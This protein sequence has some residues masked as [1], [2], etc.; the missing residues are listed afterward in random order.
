MSSD[1][2]LLKRLKGQ[3]IKGK[4]N[5]A[6][7]VPC[8]LHQEGEEWAVTGCA[9]TEAIEAAERP[10]MSDTRG[11][12]CHRFWKA[13]SSTDSTSFQDMC[14]L[15]SVRLFATPWTAAHQAPL[16]MGFPKQEY[17]SGLPF[18]TSGDLSNQGMEL[19]SPVLQADSLLLTHQGSP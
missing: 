5:R 11:D 18:P 4:S 7:F 19:S 15:I 6:S 17:C 14:L 12:I 3:G 13:Q 16:S 8:S 9:K 1:V 2:P 10:R